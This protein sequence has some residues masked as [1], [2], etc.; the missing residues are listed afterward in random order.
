VLVLLGL[1]AFHLN[2][3]LT[4]SIVT[5][6]LAKVLIENA[7]TLD[8]VMS[9]RIGILAISSHLIHKKGTSFLLFTARLRCM[10]FAIKVSPDAIKT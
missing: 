2:F 6:Q 8:H 10:Q 1:F 9:G 3:R 7:L 4:L 5:K